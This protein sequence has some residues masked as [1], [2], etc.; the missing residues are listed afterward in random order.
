MLYL[1]PH[2]GGKPRTLKEVAR[3]LGRSQV[4]YGVLR[5]EGAGG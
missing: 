1:T 3:A 4:M 2:P 5:A